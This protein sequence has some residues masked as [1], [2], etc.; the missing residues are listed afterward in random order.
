MKFLVLGS[1]NGKTRERSTVDYLSMGSGPDFRGGKKYWG[2]FE[3]FNTNISLIT[4]IIISMGD[5]AIQ[6]VM[7]RES[8]EQR[9]TQFFSKNFFQGGLEGF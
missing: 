9:K 1:R 5:D 4:N 8:L 7:K 2:H 3:T 6:K